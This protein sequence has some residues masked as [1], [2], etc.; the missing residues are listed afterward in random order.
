MSIKGWILTGLG[1][2]GLIGGIAGYFKFT[3]K[4]RQ[5]VIE[6]KELVE[7]IKA[8]QKTDEDRLKEQIAMYNDMM[9]DYGCEI[10]GVSYEEDNPWI[11]INFMDHDEDETQQFDVNIDSL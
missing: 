3:K 5:A 10:T 8:Q 1:G 4:G 2:L 9:R 7:Q 6:A 11:E